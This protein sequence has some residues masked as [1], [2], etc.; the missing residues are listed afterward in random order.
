M[1]YN[2]IVGG[3]FE[4]GEY[5]FDASIVEPNRKKA[6]KLMKMHKQIVIIKLETLEIIRNK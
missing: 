4:D 3:W 6:I 2:R 5:Y 1:N